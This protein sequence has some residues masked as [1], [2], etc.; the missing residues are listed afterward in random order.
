MKIDFTE[1][2]L[3]NLKTFLAR[4]DLKGAEVPAYIAIQMKLNN[5]VNDEDMVGIKKK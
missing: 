4:T 3:T 1:Q 5:P 2:E